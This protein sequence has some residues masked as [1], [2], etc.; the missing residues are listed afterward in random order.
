MWCLY[1]A[2][3]CRRFP[4][5]RSRV[6]D[7]PEA[8]AHARAL[9][10]QEGITDVVEYEQGDIRTIDLG[11]EICDVV[12]MGNIIHHFSDEALPTMLRNVHRALKPGGVI[13]IWDMAP[14]PDLP[15][16]DFIAE[17]FSMLFYLTSASECRGPDVYR[18][19]LTDCGFGQ[20]NVESGISPTHVLITGRR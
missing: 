15:E 18:S 19:V 11:D 7:L 9:G 17:G 8:I 5:M 13:A 20:F 14:P 6:I 4:P 16:L 1:G 3:I 12:F 2:A 10:E